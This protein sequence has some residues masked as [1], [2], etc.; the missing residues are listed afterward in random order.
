M[1]P[2]MEITCGKPNCATLEQMARA[3]LKY[4]FAALLALLSTQAV[5][6]SAR[7]V[8]A[9]EMAC[10]IHLEDRT[11]KQTPQDARRI[12][13]DIQVLQNARPYVSRTRP[14]L[15]TAVLFQRPPPRSS[16]FA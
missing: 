6:P 4:A 15:D 10:S 7:A 1:S 8:A 9:I 13:A 2:W 11:E 3:V 5:V 12:R 14:E 16:L